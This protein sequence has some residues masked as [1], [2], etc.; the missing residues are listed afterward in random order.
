M[1]KNSLVRSAETLEISEGIQSRTDFVKKRCS[2]LRTKIRFHGIPAVRK[3]KEN[4]KNEASPFS[5]RLFR[6][7][8]LGWREEVRD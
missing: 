1:A 2:L 3:T 5:E 6:I 8:I 7:T 4:F